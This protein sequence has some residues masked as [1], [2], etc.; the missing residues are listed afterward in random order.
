MCHV[1]VIDD[2]K[3][4]N[5]MSVFKYAEKIREEFR[6]LIKPLENTEPLQQIEREIRQMNDKNAKEILKLEKMIQDLKQDICKN[7]KE[8]KESLEKQEEVNSSRIVLLKLIE[9]L[10]VVEL[11]EGKINDSVKSRI[12]NVVDELQP[13]IEKRIVVDELQPYIEKRIVVFENKRD[14]EHTD[15]NWLDNFVACSPKEFKVTLRD[16]HGVKK[17]EATGTLK[18]TITPN[19]ITSSGDQQNRPQNHIPILLSNGH[20]MYI[21]GKSCSNS[22]W[23]GSYGDGYGIIITSPD[24]TSQYMSDIVVL[25]LPYSHPNG[26]GPRDF[27]GWTKNHEICYC[28]GTT[29][30]TLSDNPIGPCAFLGTFYITTK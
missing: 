15:K 8:I 30:G 6:E 21:T 17:Y 11:V 10:N 14:Q 19:N 16:E 18:S 25:V 24:T 27:K 3:Q 2:H 23:S 5:T 9:D 20:Y 12:Q 7:E 28:N 13:Y 1:C 22:G 29:F 26:D 4:H